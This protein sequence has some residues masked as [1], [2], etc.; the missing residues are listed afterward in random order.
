MSAWLGAMNFLF[1][2]CYQPG[3]IRHAWEALSRLVEPA[4]DDLIAEVEECI[5]EFE[6]LA[7]VSI[8]AEQRGMHLKI[9]D[10]SARLKSH[11]NLLQTQ[12]DP[13][14]EM[15]GLLLSQQA[16]QANI[17]LDTNHRLTDVQ[18]NRIM[19]L[20]SGTDNLDPLEILQ[21]RAFTSARL[22]SRQRKWETG[23]KF[24]TDPKFSKWNSFSTPSSIVVKGD[25]MNHQEV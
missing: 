19:D 10:T 17:N 9:S 23:N 1:I 24:W 3:K 18:L 2:R 25:Y 6:K 21:Y 20:L 15:R 5:G 12:E 7:T 14:L 22:R 8:Q 13:L 4:Y 16:I 11:E